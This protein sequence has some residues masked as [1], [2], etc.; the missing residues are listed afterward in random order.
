M[1]QTVHIPV[2]SLRALSFLRSRYAPNGYYLLSYKDTLGSFVAKLLVTKNKCP[3]F[4]RHNESTCFI[5]TLG[6]YRH[7]DR[8]CFILADGIEDFNNY[9]EQKMKESF[10]EWMNFYTRFSGRDVKSLIEK[11]IANHNM[12]DS[13]TDVE[14]FRKMF[15]RSKKTLPA[16]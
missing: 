2:K 7:M 4:V 14:F 9:A 3:A 8:K 6:T 1:A 11:F 5:I 15:V 16:A 12:P 10:L 13:E